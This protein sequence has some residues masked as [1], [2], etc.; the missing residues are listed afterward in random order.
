MNRKHKPG[1][2]SSCR[3]VIG[4]ILDD[5]EPNAPFLLLSTLEAKQKITEVDNKIM[6]THLSIIDY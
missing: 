3:L 1:R 4:A 5:V 6:I 2:Y